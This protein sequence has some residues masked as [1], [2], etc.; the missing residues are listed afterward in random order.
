LKHEGP[1]Y[2]SMANSGPG[3]N[4]SQFFITTVKTVR[5]RSWFEVFRFYY[6]QKAGA[7][8]ARCRCTSQNFLRNPS[9]WLWKP[10][11]LI[12]SSRAN[13]FLFLLSA[14]AGWSTRGLW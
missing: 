5:R 2:L 3:T 10:P 6:S 13:M 7:M 4:G 11:K 12:A 9:F 8:L 14:L 1:M